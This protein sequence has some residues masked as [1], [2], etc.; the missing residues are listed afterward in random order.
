[1][2]LNPIIFSTL[3]LSS[4]VSLLILTS[5]SLAFLSVGSSSKI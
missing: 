2:A 4:Y 5:P 3:Y 1:M